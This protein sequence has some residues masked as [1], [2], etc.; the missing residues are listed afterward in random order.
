MKPWEFISYRTLS[1][2]LASWRYCNKGDTAPALK[3]HMARKEK[4]RMLSL[5]PKAGV[6]IFWLQGSLRGHRLGAGKRHGSLGTILGIIVEYGLSEWLHVFPWSFPDIFFSFL[7]QTTRYGP[8]CPS[9]IGR[10]RTTA[11]FQS[12][13]LAP[14]EWFLLR[15]CVLWLI[16][17]VIAA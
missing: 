13:L 9:W 12:R 6:S 17:L 5:I 2:L 16:C 14:A 4:R 3:M 11:I 7:F 8:L 10:T 15:R 1:T